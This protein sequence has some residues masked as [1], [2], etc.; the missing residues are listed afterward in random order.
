MHLGNR[1]TL[2]VTSVL[3]F[4]FVSGAEAQTINFTARE[5]AL[6]NGESTEIGNVYLIN[7]HCKSVL[8]SAPEV[9]I[10]EGPP[11]VTAVINPAKVVPRGYA[12]ANPVA[13][14]KLVLTAKDIQEYSYTRMLLRINYKTFDGDRQLNENLHI[15]VYPPN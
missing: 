15:T 5:I 2:A 4:L 1:L 13:G 14:G 6:K 3:C 12:C 11:G 9:E 10:L 7:T 8:K